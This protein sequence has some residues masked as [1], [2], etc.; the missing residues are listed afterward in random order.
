MTSVT[1]LDGEVTRYAN[2][3]AGRRVETADIIGKLFFSHAIGF[4]IKQMQHGGQFRVLR[5]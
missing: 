4:S 3:A 2:D 1:A 5:I